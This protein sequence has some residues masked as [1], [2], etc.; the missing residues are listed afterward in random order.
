MYAAAGYTVIGVAPSARAAREL[1]EQAGVPAR[2]LDSRLL[3]ITNG[4]PLPER[5]IVIFDEAGMASTRQTERLF[6]HAAAV[7]A[8]VVAIGDPV[9]SRQCRRAGGYARSATV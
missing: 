7:G 9:S 5:S 8:K 4:H 3:A 1:A 6:A 2:T